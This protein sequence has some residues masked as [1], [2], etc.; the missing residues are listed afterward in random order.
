MNIIEK[1][2]GPRVPKN[3]T[4]D[5]RKKFYLPA[6]LF[7]IAAIL[8]LISIP[9]PYWEMELNAPQ[10]PK[11]LHIT[12]YV[13]ELTG[14]LFE[15]NGLNHYIGMR[16]LEEAAQLEKAMSR[17]AI[18]LLGTLTLVSI[19]IHTKWVVLMAIPAITM[20]A[21]V[22]IDLQWW[23]AKFGTELDPTA[24]LSNS[25]DPFIP[26]VLGRG[27]IAQFDTFALPGI[28]LYLAILASVLVVVGLYY[29]RQAFKPL[30][31]QQIGSA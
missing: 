20:P 2:I 1:I 21:I 19:F 13:N 11:G 28:G 7:G 8:I 26:K 31:D 16:P 3:I 6:L 17:I 4:G 25:I 30:V 23:M 29:H 15:I 18:V 27:T 12:A 5:E 22:L 24:P 14:D 9:L 10:Y